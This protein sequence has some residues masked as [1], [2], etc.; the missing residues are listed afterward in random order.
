MVLGFI[1]AAQQLGISWVDKQIVAIIEP[2]LAGCGKN[3]VWAREETPSVFLPDVILR[4]DC[5]LIDDGCSPKPAHG[6]TFSAKHLGV[7]NPRGNTE[8]GL[9][10]KPFGLPRESP[11]HGIERRSCAGDGCARSHDPAPTHKQFLNSGRL[12]GTVPNAS[13]GTRSKRLKWDCGYYISLRD[14]QA[15][16]HDPQAIM[17]PIICIHHRLHIT[18]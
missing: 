11:R 6:P 15:N 3:D 13:L 9:P 16:E 17:Y 7:Y 2:V 14:V 18:S 5:C 12:L 1:A 4:S 8:Y 10:R